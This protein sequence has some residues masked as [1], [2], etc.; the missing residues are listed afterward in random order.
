V[1]ISILPQL[2]HGLRE[3]QDIAY[4]G[5][6]IVILMFVPK[7]IASLWVLV[8]RRQETVAER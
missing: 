1:I 2:M 8:T 5:A 3:M 7:G 6:L 4:S